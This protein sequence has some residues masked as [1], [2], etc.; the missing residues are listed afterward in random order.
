[1][2]IGKNHVPTMAAQ[3][4]GPEIIGLDTSAL[5]SMMHA[6]ED[7][8]ERIPQ[9][10][11]LSGKDQALRFRRLIQVYADINKLIIPSHVDLEYKVNQESVQD[12]VIASITQWGEKVNET[13][14][15]SESYAS[16]FCSDDSYQYMEELGQ[17]YLAAVR[18][19]QSAREKETRVLLEQYHKCIKKW[20]KQAVKEETATISEV[21]SLNE[22][23]K[24]R[25]SNGTPPGYCDNS[26]NEE[27]PSAYDP[28]MT[29]A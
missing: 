13:I 5:F 3:H 22:K 4:I 11:Q 28:K 27:W 20:I 24:I 6:L 16:R 9:P 26:K 2:S 29:A 12:K 8:A 7:Q 25:F 15:L 18:T 1:M 14:L 19:F 23:A 21:E 10:I 17:K